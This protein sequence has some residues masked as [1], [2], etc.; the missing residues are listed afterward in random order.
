MKRRF[1][2][3]LRRTVGLDLRMTY[4]LALKA[5]QNNRRRVVDVKEKRCLYNTFDVW[6]HTIQSYGW[7]HP[8]ITAQNT[9]NQR[10]LIVNG[11]PP[12]GIRKR[13]TFDL[14]TLF[15]LCGDQIKIIR[16]N[17][18]ENQFRKFSNDALSPQKLQCVSRKILCKPKIPSSYT[19]FTSSN[20]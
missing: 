4:N 12:H 18:D 16:R 6:A 10:T 20:N 13:S 5:T 14:K 17:H 8:Y 1:G 2:E 9:F 3:S 7:V 19:V 11:I 15:V